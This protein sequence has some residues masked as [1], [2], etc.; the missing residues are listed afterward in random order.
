MMEIIML[1]IALGIL[2]YCLWP[3]VKKIADVNEDGKVN[4]DDAKAVVAKV[5]EV[6]VKAETALV[7]EG[8]EAALQISTISKE[9][10]ANAEAALARYK[11]H[12]EK[13]IK[14]TETKAEEVAVKVEEE[15]KEEVQKVVTKV[16]K[17]AEKAKNSVVSNTKKKK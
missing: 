13:T 2:G 11:A 3:K 6:V 5:E 15:I 17:T 9:T 10:I 12:L 14:E 7:A 1:V 4:V 8:K 16:K